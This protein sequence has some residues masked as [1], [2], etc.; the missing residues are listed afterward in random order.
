MS[1]VTNLETTTHHKN[2]GVQAQQRHLQSILD[3]PIQND[4]LSAEELMDARVSGGMTYNDFL[5][6]PGFIDFPAD[7][8]SL[9]SH[10]TKK[11]QLK[12]PFLSSPMDTVTETNMAI[13]MALN[14][15]LGVIHH[16]C[17][18]EEQAKMVKQVKK[19]ENG[20]ITD[21]VCLSPLNRVQ[22]VIDIKQKYGFCGIPITESGQ[23]H[24]KLLGIVTSRD[25]DFMQGKKETDMLLKDMM[26]TE[27]VVA[28]E[29][30]SLKEANEVIKTS[31]KGKLPIVDANGNL[32][33]LLAR[34]DLIKTRDYPL[35]TKV[36]DSKQL[37]AA[38][39]I[40]THSD[41]KIR[42]DA[43]VKAGLDVVVLDSSQGNSTFQIDM[44]RFIKETYPQLEV[45]AGNVVT[46]EQARRL[47]QAGADG[48]RVG[49]G[50]GSICIT[51]EGESDF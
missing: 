14:G 33:S 25:V 43:L 8:V 10:V 28:T 4:G 13:H 30:I 7:I 37:I 9:S 42:L 36:P 34:S 40:S 46:Q 20:F 47:I 35:A 39:A 32:V 31:R 11:I 6:L 12:M 5:I 22:D 2:T 16:N 23:L 27:L 41:D 44:I 38:A 24:S 21:P 17:S 49:M 15:G 45:I 26:T 18:V 50:S 3:Q 48:L 29:G 51:Q 1:A 19:F